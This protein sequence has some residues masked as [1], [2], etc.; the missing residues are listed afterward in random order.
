M[1]LTQAEIDE[2][3]RLQAPPEPKYVLRNVNFW[4]WARYSVPGFSGYRALLTADVV[5]YQER[6]FAYALV[7][8]DTYAELLRAGELPSYLRRRV[9]EAY[10]VLDGTVAGG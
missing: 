9:Q 10:R 7:D 1:W 2:I 6:R 4:G 5:D 3:K 8:D